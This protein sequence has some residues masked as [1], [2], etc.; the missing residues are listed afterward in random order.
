MLQSFLP[1]ITWFFF[2]IS[3]EHL[4]ERP[5][6][7][8]N[9]VRS[10]STLF[11]MPVNAFAVTASSLVSNAI[12]A[13]KLEEVMPISRRIIGD[14]Y[15]DDGVGLFDTCTCFEDIYRFCIFTSRLHSCTVCDVGI[16][17]YCRAG[18]CLVQ[19]DVGDGKYTFCVVGRIG[20][21][22]C[23]YFGHLFSDIPFAT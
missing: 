15:S 4:G 7:I 11:F 1:I 19:Y 16:L 23:L 6:A 3:I 18:K 22:C 13:G 20:Y 5:L 21:G 2:F 12:G 10:I 14:C 8:S 9:I 17:F